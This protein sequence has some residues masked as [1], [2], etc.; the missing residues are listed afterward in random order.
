LG[1]CGSSFKFAGLGVKTIPLSHPNGGFGFKILSKDKSVVFIPDNEL[2]LVHKGGKTFADYADFVKG[3]DLLIHDAEYLP[4]QYA[5]FSKG[6]GHSVYLD[7]VKL[8]AQ[9]KVKRLLMWH[10][11]Q[12]HSDQV[13]NSMLVK[14]RALAKKMGSKV[15]IEMA[16]ADQV[17]KL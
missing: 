15:K 5:A 9:A 14:A 7:T 12:D 13:L 11:N 1:E 16:A 10:L 3:V 17:I 2:T 8:A 6:Y 4:E